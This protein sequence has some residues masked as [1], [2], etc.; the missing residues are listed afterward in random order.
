MKKKMITFSALILFFVLSTFMISRVNAKSDLSLF[1]KQE[2]LKLYK[3]IEK[4][5]KKIE[6]LE[7]RL[8]DM[9]RGNDE[10]YNNIP[11]VKKMDDEA[12]QIT[13]STIGKEVDR[14]Y[15]EWLKLNQNKP[16][17]D[18]LNRAE[19]NI[20]DRI[21]ELILL[22]EEK[23][24]NEMSDVED[25]LERAESYLDYANRK[26][27]KFED[28]YGK[29]AV[30]AIRGELAAGGEEKRTEEKEEALDAT[31]KYYNC[32]RA[33]CKKMGG[34]WITYEES[35]RITQEKFDAWLAAN[36][37]ISRKKQIVANFN[38]GSDMTSFNSLPK[39]NKP[40]PDKR[41]CHFNRPKKKKY[42][43]DFSGENCPCTRACDDQ[44][45]DDYMKEQFKLTEEKYGR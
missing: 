34:E 35:K 3:D 26:L 24:E 11:K 23:L 6:G 7:K 30:A 25:D 38:R 14:K 2:I 5:E 32:L 18:S 16:F 41:G 15:Q 8:R 9:P 21:F 4:E 33:C 17:V 37:D 19:K 42:K 28:E 20:F 45:A 27:K 36:P 13:E 1:Q 29:A 10:E 44:A 40:F 22:R 43:T 12:K 31:G 39:M